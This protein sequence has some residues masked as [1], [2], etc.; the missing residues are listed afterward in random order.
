MV[1]SLWEKRLRP[2]FLAFLTLIVTVSFAFSM[3]DKICFSESAAKV[4][5]TENFISPI[6]NFNSVDWLTENTTTMRRANE[7]PSCQMRYGLLRVFGLTGIF[8][9]AVMLS[10]SG[11]LVLRNDK[12]SVQKNNVPLKLRI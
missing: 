2:I 5:A 1:T 3:R 6:Y 11:C 7:Y 8:L 4:P 9:A 10:E 12:S